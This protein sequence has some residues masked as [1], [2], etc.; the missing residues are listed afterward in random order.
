MKFTVKGRRTFDNMELIR[1]KLNEVKRD[2][3]GYYIVSMKEVLRNTSPD[4][5]KFKSLIL[6]GFGEPIEVELFPIDGYGNNAPEV[7]FIIRHETRGGVLDCIK[8]IIIDGL[9]SE[10]FD[11]WDGPKP[12]DISDKEWFYREIAWKGELLYPCIGDEERSHGFVFKI[13]DDGVSLDDV[14]MVEKELEQ[15]KGE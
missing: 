7:L 2:V 3:Y 10:P 8:E 13:K 14:A 15:G 12:E 11:Y 4:C 1:T 9:D 5:D 6:A